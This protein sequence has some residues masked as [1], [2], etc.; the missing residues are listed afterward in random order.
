M[1]GSLTGVPTN[2]L[3]AL[4]PGVDFFSPYHTSIMDCICEALNTGNYG[5]LTSEQV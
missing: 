2:S 5:E 1:R 4:P 3:T